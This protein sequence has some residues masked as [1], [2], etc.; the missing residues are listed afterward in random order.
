MP[1]KPNTFRIA[2]VQATPVFLDREKTVEKACRLIEQAAAKRVRLAVFPE[3]FV[4]TYPDWAW[5]VPPGN[6]GLQ[7]ELY[8]ELLAQAVAV[9]SATTDRLCRAA[10]KAKLNLVIGVNERNAEASDASLYNTILYIDE[11]G[12]LLGKHRKLVPTGAERLIWAQGDGSTLEAYEMPVGRVGGLI[13][14]E[15]YMPLARYAMYAW[16]TEIYVAPTWDRGGSWLATLQHI[17]KEGR[18]YVIGCCI[19]M[20]HRDVPARYPH[21]RFYDTDQGW[22][23]GGG[24]AIADPGGNIVAGPLWEKEGILTAD[25]DP[26][27]LPGT[28]WMFDVAGHYGRP[29][30]FQLTVDRSER[31]MLDAGPLDG[32]RGAAKSPSPKTPSRKA[33]PK[34]RTAKKRS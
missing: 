10:K 12:E 26:A 33:P 28:K 8:A 3:A 20:R 11:R 13:C 31:P 18:C 23:N 16:G 4:P 7:E 15:N 32:A 9:P 27:R 30:V 24:S 19:A 29:D 21:K 34:R 5:A 14:W 1:R 17:G 25:V 2:A 6:A 22:I